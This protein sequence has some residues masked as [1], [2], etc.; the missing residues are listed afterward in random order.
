MNCF[1]CGQ[2]LHGDVRTVAHCECGCSS[3]I[4]SDEVLAR[5]TA[6]T[7]AAKDKMWSAL[8]SRGLVSGE[9]RKG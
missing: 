5:R 2:E 3:I 9:R 6:A 7:I 8:K 4:M 1:K